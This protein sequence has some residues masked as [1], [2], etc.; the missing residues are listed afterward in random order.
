[1]STMSSYMFN[2]LG[3]LSADPV[4][5]TQRTV[6]NTRFANYTL[7]NYFSNVLSD[8]HVQF[9]TEQPAIMVSGT[10]GVG[11][12][13]SGVEVDSAL[14]IQNEQERPLEKLQLAQRP[15][16]SIPY[17]GK[18]SCDPVLE[19]QLQQGE[20]SLEK[21][22]VSTIMETSFMGHTLYPTD[23]YMK[24]HVKNPSYTVEESALS[25]WVRGG[26]ASREM[27]ETRPSDKS[28]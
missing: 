6:H 7:S 12:S 2:N 10:K 26:V 11:L 9:A 27:H 15:F 22:S 18:G 28:Y 14:L 20:N 8:S 21:K 17:L 13:G 1:M 3:R 4:D 24:E 5:Q 19:S 23:D 16:L 25:G